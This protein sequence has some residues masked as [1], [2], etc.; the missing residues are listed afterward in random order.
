MFD[1]VTPINGR[2]YNLE[3]HSHHKW[4]E[5]ERALVTLEPHHYQLVVEF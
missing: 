3:T 4:G 5:R 1:C 2:A